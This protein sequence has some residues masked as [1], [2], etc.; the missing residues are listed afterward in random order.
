MDRIKRLN[1]Y[2]KGFLVA[3]I[4]MVLVFTVPILYVAI[5]PDPQVTYLG[6]SD[7]QLQ[8]GQVWEED[9]AF[10]IQLVDVIVGAVEADGMRQCE[11]ILQITNEN[12][13][14]HKKFN[15]M[16]V[17][18]CAKDSDNA[19]RIRHGSSKLEGYSEP[20]DTLY[21]V[22][23]ERLEDVMEVWVSVCDTV[24]VDGFIYDTIENGDA[25][26]QF[27][28]EKG[29]TATFHYGFRAR[30]HMDVLQMDIT[31]LASK[32]HDKQY[33]GSYRVEYNIGK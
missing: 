12:V 2:Q 33:K 9:G 18:Q 1:K 4:V 19:Y 24:E 14:A 8:M 6:H 16:L 5:V 3:M 29:Q 10:E 20:D 23:P 30:E 26:H 28:V 22:Y 32:N 7:G 13:V 31:V 27:A 17:Y 25:L 11:A 15:T 21:A